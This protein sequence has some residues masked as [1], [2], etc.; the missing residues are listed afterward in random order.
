M[1]TTLLS[2]LGPGLALRGPDGSMHT[3]VDGMVDE[4]RTAFYTFLFGMLATL[5]AGAFYVWLMFPVKEAV[6][7]TLSIMM[8]TW[9]IIRYIRRL[10]ATF[11]VPKEQL[12]TG[13]YEGDEA[14][15]AGSDAGIV[16]RNELNTL[17]HLIRR[18]QQL[19]A[20]G[21]SAPHQNPSLT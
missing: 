17:S 14:T 7:L 16:N 9:M 11:A 10:F 15:N 6:V 13:K 19:K 3:A 8:I 18:E 20:Q 4:Y 1:S 12:V 2:M 21:S 5:A